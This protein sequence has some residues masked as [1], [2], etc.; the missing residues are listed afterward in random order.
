MVGRT[1]GGMSHRVA[2]EMAGRIAAVGM[3]AGAYFEIP[4]GCHP[5]RP[6]PIVAFHGDADQIALYTGSK[7]LSMPA[8]FQWVA[9]W[10]KRNDCL[11]GSETT[12]QQG[13]VSGITWTSGTSPTEVRLYTIRNGGH[14][15]PG[16]TPQPFLGKTS[17]DVHASEI[18]WAFFKAHPLLLN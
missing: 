6:I 13:D 3:V 1:E 12:F 17:K 18:M 11:Y 8:V 10:A 16:G 2:C 9:D 7:M 14:T 15:W 4:G 5:T